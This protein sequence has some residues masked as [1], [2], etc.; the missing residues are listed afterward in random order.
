LSRS[1]PL[2]GRTNFSDSRRVSGSFQGDFWTAGRYKLETRARLS[3][4]PFPMSKR[5]SGTA[6]QFATSSS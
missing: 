5:F 4:I 1:F 2:G 6:E 3:V